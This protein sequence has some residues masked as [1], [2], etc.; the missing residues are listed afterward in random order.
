MN[1]LIAG[2]TREAEARGEV[3]RRPFG[4][5]GFGRDRATSVSLGLKGPSTKGLDLKNS[6][7]YK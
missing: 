2:G 1:F 4:P 7:Q 5:R 6:A 3:C